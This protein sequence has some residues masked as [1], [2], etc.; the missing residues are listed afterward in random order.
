MVRKTKKKGKVT[1][2]P[3]GYEAISG[4]GQSWPSDD[5]KAGDMIEGTITEFDEVD[6]KRGKKTTTVQNMKVETKEGQVHTLWESAGLRPLFEYEEGTIICVI[7]L[8][9]GKAKRGQNPPRLYTLGV[10]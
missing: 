7:F 5:T 10:K 3:K 8:G 9:M 1:K 2:L 6:V 4:F